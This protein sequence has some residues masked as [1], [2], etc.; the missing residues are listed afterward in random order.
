MVVYLIKETSCR[1]LYKHQY[2]G[3]TCCLWSFGTKLDGFISQRTGIFRLQN[4]VSLN[5]RSS[6]LCIW[7]SEEQQSNWSNTSVWSLLQPKE[8]GKRNYIYVKFITESLCYRPF[9]RI[10]IWSQELNYTWCIIEE[11]S[12]LISSLLDILNTIWI[13]Y[14]FFFVAVRR[15]EALK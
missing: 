6:G 13:F 7:I 2:V 4:L 14:L 12:S 5:C 1:F 10:I 3:E 8:E 9:Q 11:L 15:H